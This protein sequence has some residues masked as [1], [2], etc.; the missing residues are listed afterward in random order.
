[1]VIFV[2]GCILQHECL[3][4]VRMGG[5]LLSSLLS[6]T[7]ARSSNELLGIELVP[8]KKPL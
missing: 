5:W 1:M 2:G 6:I 8:D 3:C 7:Y 4:D